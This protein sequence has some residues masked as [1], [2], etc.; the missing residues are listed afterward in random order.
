M[1]DESCIYCG[2][3]EQLTRDHIPPKTLFLTPLP[4]DLITVPCCEKCNSSFSKDDEYFRNMLVSCEPVCS[5][6]NA[7]A[8]NQK[9]LRSIRRPKAIGLK[10]SV[11]KNLHIVEIKTPAGLYIGKAPAIRVDRKRFNRML[12]RIAR[13]LFYKI[14]GYTVPNAY[15]I[16]IVFQDSWLSKPVEFLDYFKN[17]WQPLSYIGNRIFAYSYA[18][19]IDN[20]NAMAL[21][22]IFYEK[23]YFWGIIYPSDKLQTDGDDRTR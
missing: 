16:R 11:L 21:L 14:S 3:K 10:Q 22:F 17:D 5:D 6:S 13:G 9:F 18:I 23:L 12:D 4:S 2:S 20:P 1:K 15:D 8:I 19:C 7:Q